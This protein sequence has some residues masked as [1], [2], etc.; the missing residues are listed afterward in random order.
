ME[1]E[2]SPR[3]DVPCVS[4]CLSC[5]VFLLIVYHSEQNRYSYNN[6]TTN[7]NINMSD[8]EDFDD[9]DG[10]GDFPEDMQDFDA[11]E[12]IDDM[13][14]EGELMDGDGDE[15]EVEE[16]EEEEEEGMFMLRET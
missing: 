16:E 13:G 4:H 1:F 8:F 6:K 5:L 11:D 9:M 12:P 7:Y 10:V 2:C 15:E 14:M 3:F